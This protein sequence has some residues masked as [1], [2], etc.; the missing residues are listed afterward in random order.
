[1]TAKAELSSTRRRRSDVIPQRSRMVLGIPRATELSKDD[2]EAGARKRACLWLPGEQYRPREG[3]DALSWGHTSE[4]YPSSSL[5][6][7]P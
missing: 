1:M 7:A 6:E 5:E 4:S 3:G 2:L